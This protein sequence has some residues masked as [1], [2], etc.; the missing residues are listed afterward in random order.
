M[1]M[2]HMKIPNSRNVAPEE[3][4]GTSEFDVDSH[5]TGYPNNPHQGVD[6][7]GEQL[8]A[9]DLVAFAVANESVLALGRVLRPGEK[10]GW[11]I[12]NRLEENGSQH[13]VAVSTRAMLRLDAEKTEFFAGLPDDWVAALASNTTI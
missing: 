8:D 12:V 11:V 1:A 6:F 9:G 2:K 10:R 3:D 4:A 5:A 13:E 7:L